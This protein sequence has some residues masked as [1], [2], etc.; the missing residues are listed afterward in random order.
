[1]AEGGICQPT[2]G[3]GAT[4]DESAAGLLVDH[5]GAGAF[6]A[7]RFFDSTTGDPRLG[8]DRVKM[9]EVQRGGDKTLTSISQ[10]CVTAWSLE[11]NH[12][13]PQQEVGHFE[14]SST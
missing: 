6:S 5:G 4:L 9:D 1:V 7:C 13:R 12:P 14:L 8:A 3:L 11:A 10:Y 2:A